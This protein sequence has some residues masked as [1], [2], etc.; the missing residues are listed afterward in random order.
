[1]QAHANTRART[2]AHSRTHGNIDICKYTHIYVN[3]YT[4]MLI[5]SLRKQASDR[6][7]DKQKQTDRDRQTDRHKQTQTDIETQTERCIEWSQKERERQTDGQRERKRESSL[8]GTVGWCMDWNAISYS[9]TYSELA[10][11][12]KYVGFICE[13]KSPSYS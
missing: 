9:G 6:Q 3:I 5:F 2:D 13:L 11:F 12:S 4:H 7:T 1:M 8:T 10:D